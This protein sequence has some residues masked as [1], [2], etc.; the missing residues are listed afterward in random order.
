MKNAIYVHGKGV[1]ISIVDKN[2]NV[3]ESATGT[4]NSDI[5]NARKIISSP[6]SK[7][8]IKRDGTLWAKGMWGEK[9]KDIQ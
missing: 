1:N 5:S 7:Y 2:N 8:V 3:Y 9:I 6:S 4:D